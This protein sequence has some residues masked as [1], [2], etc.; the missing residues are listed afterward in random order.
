VQIIDERGNSFL[1]YLTC[2]FCHSNLIVRVMSLPQGLIGSAILTDLLPTE[3]LRFS[4]D[5]PL[6]LDDILAVH[7]AM[8]I[9]ELFNYLKI[10]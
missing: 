10:N 8:Q 3:V 9:N 6:S 2:A 7:Q 1:A 5:P 4:E